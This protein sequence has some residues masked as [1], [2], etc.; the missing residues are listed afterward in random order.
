MMRKTELILL[1]A[2]KLQNGALHWELFRAF[3]RNDPVKTLAR[4]LPAILD[5]GLDVVGKRKG[6]CNLNVRIFLMFSGRSSLLCWTFC[7][8]GL[9]DRA[10]RDRHRQQLVSQSAACSYIRW[11]GDLCNIH[12]MVVY[13]GV[14]GRRSQGLRQSSRLA[15]IIKHIWARVS[16]G[17]L[18]SPSMVF[19]VTAATFCC[20][21]CSL[22]EA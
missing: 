7:V 8:L 13:I 22:L 12:H 9:R 11:F 14:R 18:S 6:T 4:W 2:L 21:S 16:N 5:D 17:L 1:P 19:F 15:D 3:A 10:R 20:H